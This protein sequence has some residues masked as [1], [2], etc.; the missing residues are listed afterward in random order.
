[1]RKIR[2][3]LILISILL[4]VAY[5]ILGL[6]TN[7]ASV[8][9]PQFL[10]ERPY[11][12]GVFIG[13]VLIAIALLT[14]GQDYLK[15]WR[16]ALSRQPMAARPRIGDSMKH[17][18]YDLFISYSHKDSD[19]VRGTL[20]PKLKKHG[21]SVFV[22]LYFKG[23]AF[24]P[25]QMEEGVKDSKRVIAVFTSAYF[26]SEWATLE[27]VMAQILDPAARKRKLVPVLRENCD[28]PL[29]LAGIHYRDLRTDNEQ[30]WERLIEDLI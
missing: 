2:Y 26:E 17:Y 27:N 14:L 3:A 8:T 13:V 18:K 16:P 10:K 30:E 24:G 7:Y 28:I 29:R 6:L 5:F 23:G 21:F 20:L 11:L 25:A 9:I 22:D 4:I 12:T 15:N 19:W 1:M